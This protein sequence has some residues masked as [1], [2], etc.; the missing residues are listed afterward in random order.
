[1]YPSNY[2]APETKKSPGYQ[3]SSCRFNLQGKGHKTCDLLNCML[4]NENATPVRAF[5]NEQY[6]PQV[7]PVDFYSSVTR[8]D[9]SQKMSCAHSSQLALLQ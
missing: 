2:H 7:M 1:M 6:E 5:R 3:K 9:Q 8:E 4:K